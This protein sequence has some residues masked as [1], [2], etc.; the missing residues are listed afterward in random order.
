MA[1]ELKKSGDKV[2][3]VKKGP[4]GE[5]VV[6]LKWNT[7]GNARTTGTFIKKTV[8][9][10]IDLDLA[11]LYELT[12]GKKMVVQALGNH[13]GKFQF[14]PYIALDGDDRTGDSDDGETLRINGSM[15]SKIKRILIFTFIYDGVVNWQ[16]ANAV[17]TVKCPGSEDIVVKMDDYNTTDKTCAIAMLENVGDTFS[18]E[19]LVKFYK[20]HAAMDQAYGW[21]LKWVPGKKD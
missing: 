4:L 16:N 2:N 17:V 10:P 11:C 15:I 20:G 3:L 13:F 18:V 1:V 19:K 9:D 5:V 14:E 12:N 6:N 7:K 8:Y 21:G